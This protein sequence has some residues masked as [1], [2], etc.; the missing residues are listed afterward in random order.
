MELSSNIGSLLDETVLPSEQQLSCQGYRSAPYCSAVYQHQSVSQGCRSAS[1]YSAVMM[2]SMER[3]GDVQGFKCPINRF[4]VKELAMISIDDKAEDIRGVTKMLFKSPFKWDELAKHDKTSEFLVVA[5]IY[6]KGS[7]K[8][9]WLSYIIRRSNTIINLENLG[10]PS[11][12]NIGI[13]SC[14]Y[15]EFRKSNLMYDCAFENVEH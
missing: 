1:Y 13:T 5:Y 4:I 14:H 3:V 7:E 6:V 15:H 10:C 12:K 11:M 8:N 2:P 9:Q